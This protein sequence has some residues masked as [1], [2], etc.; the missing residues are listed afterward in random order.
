MCDCQ[1]TLTELKKQKEKRETLVISLLLEYRY[2]LDNSLLNLGTESPCI[3]NQAYSK[4]IQEEQVKNMTK[5]EGDS[6]GRVRVCCLK[7]WRRQLR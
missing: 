6:H 4:A 1:K 2:F 7:Q 5:D 3:A